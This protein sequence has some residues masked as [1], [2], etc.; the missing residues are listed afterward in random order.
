MNP[1]IRA[2]ISHK[3]NWTKVAFDLD[4]TENDPVA[5][6]DATQYASLG[7]ELNVL[8]FVQ[9]RA[10]YRANLAGSGQDVMT[11]G[12]GLSPFAIHLD[13]GVMANVDDPEKEAGVAFEFG[14]EF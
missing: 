12:I 11:A 3:T 6:E 10:G 5:F 8:R 2:G 13:L 9:L 1:M 14:I 4:L 7:A